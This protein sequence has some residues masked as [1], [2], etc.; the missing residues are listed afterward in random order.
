MIVAFFKSGFAFGAFSWF[1][2]FGF[3]LFKIAKDTGFFPPELIDTF[4]PVPEP[5]FR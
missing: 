1:S 2:F 5:D 4:E 3:G